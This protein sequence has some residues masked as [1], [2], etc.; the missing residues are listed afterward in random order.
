MQLTRVRHNY[1]RKIVKEPATK[2]WGLNRG[3]ALP[4]TVYSIESH[5]SLSLPL[6]SLG[7]VSHH[8]WKHLSAE[9]FRLTLKTASS[10]I[11]RLSL[12]SKIQRT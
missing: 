11:V 9:V 2:S 1:S 7:N 5:S 6:F 8:P 10:N 3:L 12:L 4:G